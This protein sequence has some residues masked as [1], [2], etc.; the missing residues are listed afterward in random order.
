[1]LPAAPVP[2]T[3]SSAGGCHVR[4]WS[5]CTLP[6]VTAVKSYSLRAERDF[7]RSHRVCLSRRYHDKSEHPAHS[8]ALDQVGLGGR[9]EVW[10]RR[11]ADVWS[12]QVI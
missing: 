8:E 12:D 11:G 1:M 7:R 9:P 2:I 4:D 3:K 5:P 10:A 6:A